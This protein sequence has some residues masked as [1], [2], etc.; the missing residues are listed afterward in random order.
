MASG[1]ALLLISL[2]ITRH[3]QRTKVIFSFF[4]SL[5]LTVFISLGFAGIT[6][7]F[8][9][10]FL[11]NGSPLFLG[12]TIPFGP[13]PGFLNSAG[14]LPLLSLAVGVEVFFGISIILIQLYHFTRYASRAG[15]G[16][17][18]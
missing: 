9:Y 16:R 15:G 10:N 2:L 17:D 18:I 7:S 13:N 3:V 8:L 14:I 5:G 1:T 6:A 12:R 11:A 4:E